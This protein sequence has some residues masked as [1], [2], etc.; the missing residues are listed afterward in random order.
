[1]VFHPFCLNLSSTG[2][3]NPCNETKENRLA[4]GNR[5]VGQGNS[6]ISYAAKKHKR[7]T[8]PHAP[9]DCPPYK[10]FEFS[11]FSPF[12][13]RPFY[14][15]FTTYFRG[16]Q[17]EL[18]QY[19]LDNI[20]KKIANFVTILHYFCYLSLKKETIGHPLMTAFFQQK[21]PQN[22]PGCTVYHS[23]F[24]IPN[25]CCQMAPK[26]AQKSLRSTF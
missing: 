17:V 14:L 23:M 6:P 1:M 9:G 13:G 8:V 5:I 22:Q 21:T 25:T 7:K 11:L 19:F 12:F 20:A 10:P 18:S 2:T 24:Y 26:A 16:S 15:Y 4:A 3:P